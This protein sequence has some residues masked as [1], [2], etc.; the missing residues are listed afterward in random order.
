MPRPKTP[1]RVIPMPPAPL[2][3]SAEQLLQQIR[4]LPADRIPE[5]RARLR[6]L[7]VL[8]NAV[9]A[10]LDAMWRPQRA[11]NLAVVPKPKRRK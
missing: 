5:L 6:E 4:Q 1:A 7:N 10:L 2:D 8:T 9:I 3:S 11:R